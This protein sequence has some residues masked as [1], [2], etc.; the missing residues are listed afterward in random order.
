M[1][2]SHGLLAGAEGIE[3]SAYGFGVAVE[4]AAE[5]Q[6]IED[7]QRF[8][9]FPILP[10]LPFDALLMLSQNLPRISQRRG[11]TVLNSCADAVL[12]ILYAGQLVCQILRERTSDA[13]L[14]HA[15]RLRDIF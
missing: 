4:S 9:A 1:T 10:C 7:F 11:R 8:Y 2:K 14:T 5:L 13:I 12:Q 15:Y 6:I 3:P